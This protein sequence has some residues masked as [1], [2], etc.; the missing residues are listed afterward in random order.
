MSCRAVKTVEQ[1]APVRR[2]D[3]PNGPVTRVGPVD[4][5][6]GCEEAG[7]GSVVDGD[8]AS[9][10]SAIHDVTAMVQASASA[11][12][13]RTVVERMPSMTSR[14]QDWFPMPQS[15]NSTPTDHAECQHT[16]GDGNERC[17][18]AAVGQ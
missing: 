7:G 17:C 12:R 5:T 1:S 13:V 8:T 15:P 11:V 4:G 14:G 3:A 16:G 10:P 2:R 9:G 6:N 18:G